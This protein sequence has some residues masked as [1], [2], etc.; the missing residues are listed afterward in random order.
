M[1]ATKITN[2]NE[3]RSLS[4]QGNCLEIESFWMLGPI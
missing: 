1:T 3:L 4:H 2:D